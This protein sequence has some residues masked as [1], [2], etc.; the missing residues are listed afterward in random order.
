MEREE[1][2]RTWRTG[3]MMNSEV[4]LGTERTLPGS[5]LEDLLFIL[6][7]KASAEPSPEASDAERLVTDGS[8]SEDEEA[9]RREEEFRPKR[10]QAQE[11]EEPER[12]TKREEVPEEEP[13]TEHEPDPDPFEYRIGR[14]LRQEVQPRLLQRINSL[15]TILP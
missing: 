8:L 9:D 14:Y 7:R 13:D 6:K 5:P 3:S 4:T 2:D 15:A 10:S 11:E 1:T 12:N